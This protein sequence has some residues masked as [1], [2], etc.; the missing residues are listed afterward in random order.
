MRT[1]FAPTPSG[2]L[3]IG[4]AWSFVL[5]WL[6]ARS[7]GGLIHLRI[8]DLDVARF[9]EEYLEDIFASLQW[10]GLDWDSGPRNTKEFQASFSQRNRMPEYEHALAA[11]K[12]QVYGCE[13]S[14]EQ[15][16]KDS[17][18]ADNPSVY[19]GTCRNKGLGFEEG[20]RAL[21]YRV[22]PEPV[23]PHDE[24]GKPFELHPSQDMGDFVVQ[25]R[26][27]DPGYQLAS[28]VDD[29]SLSIDFVVRGQD[30]LPSTGAQVS[31]AI[32]LGL[33]H[34]PKA[35]FWHHALILDDAGEKLSKSAGAESLQALRGKFSDPAPVFRFFARHMGLE[36]SGIKSAHDLL[37]GFRVEKVATMPLRLSEFWR[38]AGE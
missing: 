6:M 19:A 12:G 16:K 22:S 10:L 34:F 30:L 29:E 24:S 36:P 23:V 35:R 11:L 32:S 14:R 2:Y 27:G 26:N 9:R 15:A 25:Q 8:D 1:R 21:R 37:D 28:V 31:L 18:V 33:E 4:N 13:C 20:K 5:T 38:E 3:H 7:Q 17:E